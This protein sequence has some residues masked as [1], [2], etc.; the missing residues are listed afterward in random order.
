MTK[1]T[2]KTLIFAN[3]IAICGYSCSSGS[4][5]IKYAKI[6]EL[7]K[8]P[9]V[10]IEGPDAG[11]FPQQMLTFF[12]KDKKKYQPITADYDVRQNSGVTAEQLNKVFK[13]VM[14][15]K[16]EAVIK[17]GKENNIDPAFLAAIIYQESGAASNSLYSRK[18]NNIMGRMYR[19]KKGSW[20]PMSFKSVESCVFDTA[21]HLRVNYI[22]QGRFTVK[23]IQMKYCPIVTNKKSKDFNDSRHV[24]SFWLKNIPKHMNKFQSI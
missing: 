5:S 21:R 2:I 8:S 12:Q 15:G 9:K 18:F 14:K 3:M 1:K 19:T 24:N 11:L 20:K 16:G 13:G 22:E 23:Q 4:N 17:A 10:E 6:H 7:E